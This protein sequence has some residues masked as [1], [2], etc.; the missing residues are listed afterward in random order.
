ME[1]SNL[2]QLP[3]SCAQLLGLVQAQRCRNQ[4][5]N[6]IRH[7]SQGCQLPRSTCSAPGSQHQLATSKKEEEH[8]FFSSSDD[9]HWCGRKR[10]ILNILICAWSWRKTMCVSREWRQLCRRA[11][12]VGKMDEN[13]AQA[14]LCMLKRALRVPQNMSHLEGETRIKATW[15]VSYFNSF[16]SSYK[17]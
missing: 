5:L 6:G 7:C 17:L 12:L 11:G 15:K 1:R 14:F 2:H 9:F 13:V 10:Y 8:F 3:S 16:K 4:Y